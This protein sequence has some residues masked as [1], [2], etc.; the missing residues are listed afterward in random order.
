MPLV[1]RAPQDTG[2]HFRHTTVRRS[3]EVVYVE[4]V[5]HSEVYI[6]EPVR[7]SVRVVDADDHQHEFMA[8][9]LRLTPAYVAAR[10]SL[11][12]RN[13]PSSLSSC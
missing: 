1:C 10:A 7:W 8:R 13:N 9:A 11:S 6:D 4:G 2:E 3:G 5:P 12:H